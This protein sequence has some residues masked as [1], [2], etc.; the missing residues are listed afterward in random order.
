M[1]SDRP[2]KN[3]LDRTLPLRAEAYVSGKACPPLLVSCRLLPAKTMLQHPSI[4]HLSAPLA[5][6]WTGLGSWS[7]LLT[8]N[9]HSHV[10]KGVGVECFWPRC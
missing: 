10:V 6:V 8:S 9:K 4:V 3:K 7:Q 5:L 1:H 2:E